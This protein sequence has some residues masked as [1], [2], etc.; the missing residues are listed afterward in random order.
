MRLL[1]VDIGEQDPELVADR[2]WQAG[3]A[4]I[5][6]VDA[7]TLRVGVGDDDRVAFMTALADLGP[8]DVTEHEAVELTTRRVTRWFADRQLVFDV[9][10]TVFGDGGHATTTTCLDVLAD[11]VRPGDAVLDVGCGSGMLSLLAAAAGARVTAIDIDRSAVA[12]TLANATRNRLAVEASTTALADVGS[13]YDVVAA[14]ITAGGILALV[15]DL[16]RVT[17]RDGVLV[18]SGILEDRWPVVRER[19]DGDVVRLVQRDGWVTAAVRPADP[20]PGPG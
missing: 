14:N 7:S 16:V 11:V 8:V 9:P 1:A 18:V 13:R 19:L 5:W 20:G 3:A 6:E 4:G 10:P 15:D 12:A 2:C 17:A